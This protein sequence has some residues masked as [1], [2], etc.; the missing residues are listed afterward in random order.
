M[1]HVLTPDPRIFYPPHAKANH[2]DSAGARSL[3]VFSEVDQQFTETLL[4]GAAGTARG[5]LARYINQLSN[6][7]PAGASGGGVLPV[8]E[9]LFGLGAGVG[10]VLIGLI[11]VGNVEVVNI[12]LC[13]FDSTVL[14]LG[15]DLGTAGNLRIT[16]FAPF[17]ENSKT[18]V[19]LGDPGRDR[20]D[21]DRKG[22]APHHPEFEIGL[23][24]RHLPHLR[25]PVR[26]D[27]R[28]GGRVSRSQ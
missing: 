13:L 21:A 16:L 25:V 17:A 9:E 26:S 27:I 8:G 10:A 22:N 15:G 20:M 14:L 4:S 11:V 6:A 3:L 1:N 24:E 5:A 7:L 28:Y 23:T 2:L 12:L 19:S 18:E